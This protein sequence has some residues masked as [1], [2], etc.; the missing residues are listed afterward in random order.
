MESKLIKFKSPITNLE[1][2]IVIFKPKKIPKLVN[3]FIFFDGQIFK[4]NI[5]GFNTYDGIEIFKHLKNNK[6]EN[7]IIVLVSS[8]NNSEDKY[9]IR[10]KEWNYE[11]NKKSSFLQEAIKIIN[12]NLISL[13]IKNTFGFG[14]SLSGYHI[15]TKQKDFDHVVS[16]SPSSQIKYLKNIEDNA[17]IYYGQEEYAINNLEKTIEPMSIFKQ[18]NPKLNIINYK[19]LKHSFSSWNDH[20]DHIL[21]SSI[22][23]FLHFQN[24]NIKGVGKFIHDGS[25][26]SFVNNDKHLKIHYNKLKSMAN[27]ISFVKNTDYKND[28]K[29]LDEVSYIKTYYQAK[30][31]NELSHQDIIFLSQELKKLHNTPIFKGAQKFK[32]NNNFD[33]EKFVMSHGDI[34]EKN[35]LFASDRCYFIDFE[36]AMLHSIYW[37]IGSIFWKF[38]FNLNE[39]KIFLENYDSTN[40]IVDENKIKK[41][42]IILKQVEKEFYLENKDYFITRKDNE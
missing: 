14:F 38:N 35:V 21:K 33:K 12:K 26:I 15:L 31:K 29:V 2:K 20:F 7:N 13:N 36:W 3:V 6:L 30:R 41:M 11:S 9:K 37:D 32:Y 39:Q 17:S 22:L 42:I 40:K 8:M 1:N 10:E 19:N 34:N 25:N 23:P 16:V 18:N 27:E 4:T 28:Y 24:Q 5:N